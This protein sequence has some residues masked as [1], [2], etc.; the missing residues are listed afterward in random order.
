MTGTPNELITFLLE[1][2]KEKL[3]DLVE[4]RKKRSLNS[5]SYM[6]LLINEIANVMRMSK[7][8]VYL[9]MLKDYGQSEVISL[10]SSINVDGYFKYYEVIGESMLNNKEF[11][12][13]RIFKGS[14][15]YDTREMSILL[16][17]VVE[18][19]KALGIETMTKDE[20]EHL[21]EMWR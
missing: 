2:D 1:Q 16:Q 5:N 19:A 21:K 9:Q 17:G 15:E 13:I 14:S 11:K 18:E 4:H 3:F 10:L 7:E 12:H 8:E 6:W 20:I